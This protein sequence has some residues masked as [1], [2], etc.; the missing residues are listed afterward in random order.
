M[1]NLNYERKNYNF[2]TNIGCLTIWEPQKKWL[3]KELK[4]NIS[5]TLI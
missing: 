3:R 1:E 4:S 5:I 2:I